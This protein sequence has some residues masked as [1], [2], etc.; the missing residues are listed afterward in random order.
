MQSFLDIFQGSTIAHGQ[1]I[2][3]GTE[4]GAARYA[5]GGMT[6]DGVKRHFDGE[7]R[8][9]L[10]PT[11]TEGLSW[12]GAVDVDQHDADKMVDHV[13]LAAYCAKAWPNGTV[14]R[15]RRGGAHVWFFLQK[16]VD[17]RLFIKFLQLVAKSLKGWG[18]PI[19]VFPKQGILTGDNKGNFINLPYCKANT[20]AGSDSY[21]IAEPVPGEGAQ[22]LTYEEFV[23]RAV[24]RAMA[25]EDI[26]HGLNLPPSGELDYSKAPPCIER[27]V[28]EGVAEGGRSNALVQFAVYI[29]RTGAELRPAVENFNATVFSKPMPRSVVRDTLGRVERTTYGYMCSANPMCD[30]CD[31]AEC[32]RREFGISSSAFSFDINIFRRLEKIDIEGE[33]QYRLQ[34]GTRMVTIDAQ[35][36]QSWK[37]IKTAVLVA[38]NRL[39]PDMK[40]GHWERILRGLMQ[41][42]KVLAAPRGSAPDH[43]LRAMI[44]RWLAPTT[45][46][47][48]TDARNKPADAALAN[49][50]LLDDHHGL[51]VCFRPEDLLAH[52]KRRKLPLDPGTAWIIASNMGFD[53]DMLW[54]GA[55]EIEV[56][57]RGIEVTPAPEF[58]VGVGDAEF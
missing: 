5:D 49:P 28:R 55:R 30:L 6:L 22:P 39:L 44:D 34:I 35:Q 40:N 53:H 57:W 23:A 27:M 43:E 41:D 33:P 37:E 2:Q 48:R 7:I 18:N 50:I 20:A 32:E 14:V 42:M 11:N 56:W 15:T 54:D 51:R 25:L 17:S 47:A 8:L 1:T 46:K 26:Q 36:L 21:A 13:A 9:G 45:A 29:Q 16:P 10:V 3:D 12:C 52:A 31:K 38:T 24:S 4:K 19:E 58:T